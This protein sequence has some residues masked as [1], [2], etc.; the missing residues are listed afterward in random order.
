MRSVDLRPP[1]V[2][3]TISL[4]LVLAVAASCGSDGGEGEG[5]SRFLISLSGYPTFF[6]V[7]PGLIELPGR[8]GRLDADAL[9]ERFERSASAEVGYEARR[10][11][12]LPAPYSI[13]RAGGEPG[14][15]I[16][17]E[18]DVPYDLVIDDVESRFFL[19]SDTG[20][21][22]SVDLLA[23]AAQPVR[24]GREV[25]FESAIEGRFSETVAG[26]AASDGERS[27]RFLPIED[28]SID[29]D[30]D[31]FARPFDCRDDD[32]AISPVV[33][34]IP[35]D[36]IDQDCDGLDIPDVDRDGHPTQ[37][38]GGDD[39]DD[40]N[41]AVRPGAEEIASDSIDNDCDGVLEFDDDGDGFRR[42]QGGPPSGPVDCD[43]GDATVFPGAPERFGNGVDNNCNGRIPG[44]KILIVGD[45][46][47]VGRG[48]PR[49]IA[50][51]GIIGI[52]NRLADAA[53][54]R[55]RPD[56]DGLELRDRGR[57]GRRHLRV[58]RGAP[59]GRGGPDLGCQ[60]HLLR[61]PPERVHPGHAEH[62]RHRPGER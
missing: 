53:R 14:Y 31:L 8:T 40:G 1:N 47:A 37:E 27:I 17:V 12:L 36:G 32:V 5:P 50:R 51:P 58:P 38:F 4:A 16:R 44:D 10:L 61:D 43:D 3:S 41:P 15:A 48:D 2:R 6:T 46:I 28:D 45:S 26:L 19:T 24:A 62:R 56:S 49:A 52:S 22:L 7:A 59:T 23:L 11:P 21:H 29:A 13:E 35:G 39:C 34:E 9:V 57:S 33:P 60:R 18:P 20:V 25:R 42:F 30:G 54:D 55:S